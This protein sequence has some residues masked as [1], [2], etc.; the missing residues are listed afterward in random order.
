LREISP[1][2]SS[3]APVIMLTNCEHTPHQKSVSRSVFLFRSDH[4]Q[5][6]SALTAELTVVVT[7]HII[8]NRLFLFI[9]TPSIGEVFY[10]LPLL[11]HCRRA[12][13]V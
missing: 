5:L 7:V 1:T 8:I 10:V 3:H 9:P 11:Q 4:Q 13:S 6:G 12:V 2:F